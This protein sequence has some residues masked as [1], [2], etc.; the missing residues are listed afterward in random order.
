MNFLLDE[1]FS[2]RF[3]QMLLPLCEREGDS[4]QHIVADLGFQGVDDEK[5]I[6]QL[7]SKYQWVLLTRDDNLRKLKLQRDAW[8][9]KGIIGFFFAKQWGEAPHNEQAWRLVRWW[10]TLI[11]LAD[12]AEPGFGYRVPWRGEPKRRLKPIP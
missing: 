5:W 2:H 1:C 9:Q 7:D 8:R 3:V 6:A 12:R 4:V 10:P 11:E